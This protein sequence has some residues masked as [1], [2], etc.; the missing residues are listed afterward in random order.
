[1]EWT[2]ARIRALRSVL[3]LTQEEFASRLRV[4][5]RTVR[6]WE[7]AARTP[8]LKLQRA[9]DDLLST[10]SPEQRARWDVAAGEA[11]PSF[12]VDLH[13]TTQV[14]PELLMHLTDLWHV[15]VRTDN[16]LGPRHALAGVQQQAGL[17]EQLLP[18]ARGTVRTGL[19]RLGAWYAESASWLW[20]D[21][22]RLDHAGRW[23][24]RASEWSHEADDRRML[25]WTLFRRSQQA[26]AR[27]DAGAVVGLALAA[28]READRLPPAML[29][30][31]LLQEARGYALD[32]DEVACQRRLDEAG[33]RAA[34]PQQEGDA[35]TGHGEFCTESYVEVQ[36]AAC[37]TQLGFPERAVPI[38]ERWMPSIPSVYV[39]NR[40][41]HLAQLAKAHAAGGE[42]ERAA[43]VAIEALAIARQTGSGRGIALVAELHK[44]LAADMALPAVAR[45][46]QQLTART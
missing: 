15:L 30:S 39:R 29:A 14:T 7:G 9:L 27:R 36:R 43:E 12:E 16:L 44:S 23:L 19:L 34:S 37:W 13:M 42:P 41:I 11:M 20:E 28:Q 17:I 33:V 26:L 24:A 46:R 6:S 31:A 3:R 10:T 5:P 35:R 21:A 32:G 2:P 25:A 45:L 18:S 8:T 22:G 40:G 1:M 4:A 38:Y